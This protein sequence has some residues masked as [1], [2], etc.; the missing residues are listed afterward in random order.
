MPESMLIEHGIAWAH[1]RDGT[2]Y[3]AHCV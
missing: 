3:H 1:S 2:F